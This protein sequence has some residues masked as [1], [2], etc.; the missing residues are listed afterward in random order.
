MGPSKAN[1]VILNLAT[2][3]G[4]SRLELVLL[5]LEFALINPCG[6][7]Y[8]QLQLVKLSDGFR[9]FKREQEALN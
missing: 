3:V 2:S 8:D 5:A 7:A 6:R 4:F 9:T 1:S